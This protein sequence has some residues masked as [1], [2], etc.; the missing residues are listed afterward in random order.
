[1]E[2]KGVWGPWAW[3][4]VGGRLPLGLTATRARDSAQGRV[5]SR[6]RGS[7]WPQVLGRGEGCRQ[8]TVTPKRN[9]VSCVWMDA[10]CSPPALAGS[11]GDGR[12]WPPGHPNQGPPQQGRGRVTSL[13][14]ARWGGGHLLPGPEGSYRRVA[15]SLGCPGCVPG[16]GHLPA[17][18]PAFGR[19]N[20]TLA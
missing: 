8:S 17:C 14:E 9:E 3:G 16:P 19:P 20:P 7:L 5:N 4:A 18:L 12:T 6:G 2:G 13:E 1:M 15:V 10:V 11:R